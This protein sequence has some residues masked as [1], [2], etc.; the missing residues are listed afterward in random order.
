VLIG[1]IVLAGVVVNNAIVLVD[2]INRRR[3]LEGLDRLAAIREA[4]RIR[5]RPIM[6]TT[7]TTV[8][9]LAPLA[10]GFG[11]GSE[12]QRPLAITIIAGL[13][14]STLLTLLVI[15]VLYDQVVR[16]VESWLG[17]DTVG[18]DRELETGE[19]PHPATVGDT[20]V[21]EDPA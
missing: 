1:F 14:S 15:P 18:L 8:L 9:G 3:R 17:R 4:G 13:T 12:I 20:I 5:L 7:A 11:E 19:H 2:A 16:R 21:P 10:M 6:I